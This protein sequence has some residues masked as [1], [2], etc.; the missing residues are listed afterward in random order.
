LN[1]IHRQER[2]GGYI[3]SPKRN[4][5]GA[6]KPFRQAM[7]EGSPGG[8]VSAFVE[9]SIAAVRRGSTGFGATG[10][11]R[12]DIGWKVLVKFTLL[13]HSVK[14]KDHM[15]VLGLPPAAR[16]PVTPHRQNSFR[17]RSIKTV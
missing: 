12:D 7:C 13:V 1:Q 9:T 11:Y 8:L 3:W 15:G 14:P 16:F 17:L 5:N 6:K 2:A 4:A 10:Q